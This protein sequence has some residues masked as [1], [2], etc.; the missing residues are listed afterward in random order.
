MAVK[1]NQQEL[2]QS[3]EDT[4]RFEKLKDKEST[5]ELDFGHGRI[6]NRTCYI[7]SDLQYLDIEKW[8]DVKTVIKIVSERYNKTKKIQEAPSLRYYISSVEASPVVFNKLIRAHWSVENNLHWMM[9]LAMG[10]DASRKRAKNSPVN[11][12]VVFKTALAML[13]KYTPRHDKK[14]QPSIKTKRK[15]GGWA[16]KCI[17]DMLK[18]NPIE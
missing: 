6:E 13:K 16:D 9:D 2:Y 10:E 18:M 5:T 3:I 11:F 15:M 14:K 7:S 1:N 12:S 4:F 8:T 17:R